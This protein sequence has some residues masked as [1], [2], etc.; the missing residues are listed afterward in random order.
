M[1]AEPLGLPSLV[2]SCSWG[3]HGEGTR[4]FGSGKKK[5]SWDVQIWG[6]PLELAGKKPLS[7]WWHFSC[8]RW[9]WQGLAIVT[10]GCPQDFGGHQA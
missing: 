1:L 3:E 10:P 2:A 5:T 7:L 9:A 6:S 4:G 8:H